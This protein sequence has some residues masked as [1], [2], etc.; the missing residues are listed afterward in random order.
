MIKEFQNIVCHNCESKNNARSRK[1]CDGC[2]LV[3][4]ELEQKFPPFFD[5]MTQFWYINN[6]RMG[7][8]HIIFYTHQ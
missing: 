6:V 3:L 8:A 1:R 4:L 5:T 7:N 2:I